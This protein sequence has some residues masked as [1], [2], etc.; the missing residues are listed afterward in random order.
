MG[1]ESLLD[2]S[3]ADARLARETIQKCLAHVVGD[4]TGRAYRRSDALRKRRE[5]LEAWSQYACPN[6]RRPL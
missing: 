1:L 2:V 6:W 5:V 3:L 4:E